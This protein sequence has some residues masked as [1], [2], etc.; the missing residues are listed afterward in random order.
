M[1]IISING[2]NTNVNPS[3]V[4][5][6]AYQKHGLRPADRKPNDF[7]R[8]VA[9]TFSS[10]R[11][12]PAQETVVS[13]INGFDISYERITA[14]IEENWLDV[15]VQYNVF[16]IKRGACM[17]D[18]QLIDIYQDTTYYFK[19]TEFI[20]STKYGI[21]IEY[22][23]IEQRSDNVA[24]IRFID[25]NSLHFPREDDKS[26]VSCEYTDA[27]LDGNSSTVEFSGK[28]GLL[29][30]TFSTNATLEVVQS[31]PPV[32][33]VDV[34]GIDPQYLSR[35]YIQNYKLL[36]EYFGNQ[37]RAIYSTMGMT[38]SN[39][40]SVPRSMLDIT[41]NPE[42]DLRSGDMCYLDDETG[43]YKRSVASR[44]KFSQVI[45]LYL[46]EVNEGN[47]LIYT[48]GVVTC[49]AAKHNLPNDH[50]LLNLLTGH[51]YFLEDAN[52]LFDTDNQI[53]TIDN[54]VLADS[55]GRISPRY[56]PSSVRVGFATACN[57]IV[58]NIDHSN[59]IATGNL[60]SLFGNFEEYQKEYIANDTVIDMDTENVDLTTRNTYLQDK[61]NTVTTQIGTNNYS[62]IVTFAHDYSVINAEAF[63]YAMYNI[64]PRY[65]VN[66]TTLDAIYATDLAIDPLVDLAAFT[67]IQQNDIVTKLGL[68]NGLKNIENLLNENRSDI[69]TLLLAKQAALSS[70]LVTFESTGDTNKLAILDI[71]LKISRYQLGDSYATAFDTFEDHNLDYTSNTVA[72]YSAEITALQADKLVLQGAQDTDMDA[73]FAQVAEISTL[74]SM[75]TKTDIYI[76]NI[77]TLLDNA[78]AQNIID[79]AEI[80]DNILTISANTTTRDEAAGNIMNADSN[81]LDIFL[82]DDHQRVVFNYTYITDR[83]RKRLILVDQLA[84]DLVKANT[85]YQA[86]QSNPESTIIE[87]IAALEEVNRI[88]NYIQSN[89]NLISNYTEEY[90][91]IRVYYF[92][93]PPIVEG[94]INFDD[95]GYSNQKIGTYRYG[96]D[97]YQTTYGGLATNLISAAC[98]PYTSPDSLI[99][100]KNT[101]VVFVD[102]LANDGHSQGLQLTMNSVDAANHG[103]STLVTRFL[104]TPDALAD[105][106]LAGYTIYDELSAE[107][108]T[109]FEVINGTISLMLTGVVDMSAYTINDSLGNP[110]TGAIDITTG[111]S[112]IPDADYSGLDIF[113]YSITDP[114]G[115]IATGTVNVQVTGPYTTP[116]VFT[117]FT[118]SANNT[119]DVLANDGH[120][121][122]TAYVMIFDVTVQPTHGTLS[123]IQG[124]DEANPGSITYTPDAGYTGNDYFTYTITD[125][126]AAAQA[127]PSIAVSGTVQVV[128]Q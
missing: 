66:G 39:F 47:H 102:V 76:D 105:A 113:G 35:L 116:D 78:A 55:S 109:A 110:A 68:W 103:T 67:T 57:Q 11:E 59:E 6:G 36:F 37:S 117:V 95:G 52:S 40:I 123:V 81:K 64:L 50:N 1:P 86:V 88:E 28:P 8:M 112:Y 41:G 108:V 56:Y 92:A 15:D 75:L 106:N 126:I 69:N 115:K 99:I 17:I 101:G 124:T 65:F 48:S 24:R 60:L 119:L 23:Y 12:T 4:E 70:F 61:I 80:A 128:V 104:F 107:V 63:T 72:D 10:F 118:D 71:D 90:N 100:A 121:D 26:V 77:S 94:D 74:T 29:V 46:N 3:T 31:N 120:T 34:P 97:D 96:C 84:D 91:K 7:L 19:D 5:L 20:P 9:R 125:N 13:Y 49:D 87:R 16:T 14:T 73:Y 2:V 30:G 21:V 22:D 51:H 45:G 62:D 18:N 53:R 98:G 83:L 82:M 54:Y 127:D 43:K 114:D 38:N 58:I 42:T 111:I 32:A 93:L 25:Y 44:Q 27:S 85:T 122:N 33:G 79:N 89:N